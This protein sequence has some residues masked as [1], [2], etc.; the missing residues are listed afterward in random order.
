MTGVHAT[1][2]LLL[3]LLSG[4][5]AGVT[6]ERRREQCVCETRLQPHAR[7]VNSHLSLTK[8]TK[9]VEPGLGKHTKGRATCKSKVIKENPPLLQTLCNPQVCCPRERTRK[10]IRQSPLHSPFA[11]VTGHKTGYRVSDAKA[12]ADAK[13]QRLASPGVLPRC[14]R[15][16]PSRGGAS[17]TEIWAE[18]RRRRR[19]RYWFARV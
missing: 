6:K 7:S 3:L 15:E 14:G 2:V 11:Y 17:G 4:A 9:T 13:A 5:V 16:C 18:M 12:I 8:I 10:L 19:R 1:L